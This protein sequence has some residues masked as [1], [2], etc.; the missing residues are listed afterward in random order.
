MPDSL[1]KFNVNKIVYVNSINKEIFKVDS[2]LEQVLCIYVQSFRIDFTI[3][4]ETI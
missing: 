1:D 4:P 3:T 2:I